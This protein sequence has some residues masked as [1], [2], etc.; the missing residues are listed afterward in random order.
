M[1]KQ[2]KK[3]LVEKRIRELVPELGE[4]SFGC[5][6]RPKNGG[7]EATFLYLGEEENEMC[8]HIPYKD[9]EVVDGVKAN[10]NALFHDAKI[11]MSEIIGHPI[12]LEHILLAI[13]K[14]VPMKEQIGSFFMTLLSKYN[15]SKP[16]EEQTP[17]TYDFL[18]EIL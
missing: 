6:V 18:A 3:E 2:S 1:Q 4:L 9:V 13:E 7:T 17:E 8:I 15:L 16:F 5:K 10:A 12:H 11:D 14:S